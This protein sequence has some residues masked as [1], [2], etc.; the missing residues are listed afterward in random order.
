MYIIAFLI[1]ITLFLISVW[2]AKK[3]P[4]TLW[5]GVFVTLTILYSLIVLGIILFTKGVYQDEVRYIGVVIVLIILTILALLFLPI[6]MVFSLLFN[7]IRLIKR[8]GFRFSNLLS[9]L[10]GMGLLLLPFLEIFLGSWIGKYVWLRVLVYSGLSVWGYIQLIASAYTLSHF[11]NLIH[12]KKERLDYILVL[13]CGLRGDKV[14][15]LL[16]SRIEKGIQLFQKNPGS[17]LIFSGGKGEDEAISEGEAMAKYGLKRGLSQEDILVENQSKNTRE[18]LL[19]SR[20]LM[21]EE[22]RIALVTNG[23]HVFRALLLAKELGIPCIGYGAKTKFYF[24]L[25][26]YIRELV[27]YF[28]LHKRTHLI[29]AGVILL[30]EIA[31]EVLQMFSV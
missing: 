3:E 7:G 1:F 9:L 27:G 17:K 22:G 4:R 28:V 20:R 11:L 8:E 21:K 10:L 5:L 19:F 26:A 29:V 25:N 15:P 23:Y 18:N 6:L 24:S 31:R 13:G 12:F 16:A 30:F 14:T 2:I